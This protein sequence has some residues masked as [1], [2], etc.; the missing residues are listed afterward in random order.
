M[1]TY[2][3]RPDGFAVKPLGRIK[4][5][6]EARAVQEFGP[7]L[8]TSPQS[9]MGQIIGLLADA[10]AEAWEVGLAVAQSQDVDQAEG[11]QLEALGRLRGLS[12]AGRDDGAFAIAIA[13]GGERSPILR[14]LTEALRAVQGVTYVGVTD[15][16]DTLRAVSAPDGALAVAVKGGADDLVAA[17]MARYLPPGTVLHGNAW[18]EHIVEG[19][20]RSLAVI[21]P[22]E[23][24]VAVT[25]RARHTGGAC[26]RPNEAAIADA[27]SAGWDA[28]RGHGKGV[29]E[30]RLRRIVEGA[31]SG[32][33]V[34]QARARRVSGGALDVTAPIG[35][36][37]IATIAAG[38]LTV[39]LE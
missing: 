28:I 5:D 21:R 3:V 8:I 22:S 27:V 30:Y 26:A 37:E 25:V 39:T 12:R 6:I 17:T 18:V 16:P 38:D 20:C 13:G 34:I 24:P 36:T 31:Y 1:T 29:T 15:D 9:P 11:V 4:A 33:E 23:V 10:A 35:L 2:G 14:D 19:R 7:G 32:V